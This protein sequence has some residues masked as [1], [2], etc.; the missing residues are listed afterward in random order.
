MAAF[1]EA[2]CKYKMRCRMHCPE[3]AVSGIADLWVSPVDTPILESDCLVLDERGSPAILKTLRGGSVVDACLVYRLGDRSEIPPRTFHLSETAGNS[4]PTGGRADSC[5]S[6]RTVVMSGQHA[7]HGAGSHGADS[8]AAYEIRGTDGIGVTV[9]V[10]YESGRLAFTV[11]VSDQLLGECQEEAADAA[12]SVAVYRVVGSGGAHRVIG[13]AQL[14]RHIAHFRDCRASAEISRPVPPDMSAISGNSIIRSN[15]VLD[16]TGCETVLE[17]GN[18]P[19]HVALVRAVIGSMEYAGH[20]YMR[21]MYIENDF[22]V[23]ITTL[24]AAHHDGSV[25][26]LSLLTSRQCSPLLLMR[27]I[28]EGGDA[29]GLLGVRLLYCDYFSLVADNRELVVEYAYPE[30][31]LSG[32][33][34]SVFR[35]ENIVIERG[36]HSLWIVLS[37]VRALYPLRWPGLI[38]S[39]LLPQMRYLLGGPYKFIAVLSRDE[40]ER[41]G[42]EYT[43]F[44]RDEIVKLGAGGDNSAAQQA[45]QQYVS[46]ALQGKLDGPVKFPLLFGKHGSPLEIAFLN[47]RPF[48]R[49]DYFWC[50]ERGYVFIPRAHLYD[51]E[52]LPLWIELFPGEID[53]DALFAED[54]QLLPALIRRACTDRDAKHLSQLIERTCTASRNIQPDS[55]RNISNYTHIN[56]RVYFDQYKTRNIRLINTC[57]CRRAAVASLTQPEIEAAGQPL[58]PTGLTA[59][60]V[61]YECSCPNA[62]CRRTTLVS[63]DDR[64]YDLISVSNCLACLDSDYTDEPVILSI[65]AYFSFFFLPLS[66]ADSPASSKYSI[67]VD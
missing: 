54:E 28:N 29:A 13:Q 42:L 35:D 5:A 38:V 26:V 55:Q 20:S 30:Y 21:S 14:M 37:L 2:I 16:M 61:L 43:W 19:D 25:V 49:A 3:Q 15:P 17:L 57:N 27:Y 31:N 24:V 8:H 59:G 45:V 50:P 46:R 56:F 52:P 23:F 39:D 11:L 58:R 9:G 18:K 36:P 67:E 12:G 7:D 22:P 48:R 1:I 4:K 53:Y 6:N 64:T 65:L 60:A 62:D 33:T 32:L 41:T 10:A 63:T 66:E 44:G 51:E 47:S 34:E 40:A